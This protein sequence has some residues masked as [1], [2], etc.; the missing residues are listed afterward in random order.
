ML[1]LVFLLALCLLAVVGCSRADN[2]KS[3]AV[4]AGPCDERIAKLERDIEETRSTVKV[5]LRDSY[6]RELERLADRLR[7][8]DGVEHARTITKEQALKDAAKLFEDA[9]GVME[10]LPGN[11]FP[12]AI[13]LTVDPDRSEAIVTEARSLDGVDDAGTGGDKANKARRVLIQRYRDGHEDVCDMLEEI[14]SSTDEPGS[15]G[16][17]N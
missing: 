14:E 5:F 12:A 3:V 13:E 15:S 6:V 1:R 4:P 9:P 17:D 8:I 7:G 11:P 2:D 10:N 16:N